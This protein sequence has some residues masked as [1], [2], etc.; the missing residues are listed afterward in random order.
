MSS[1]TFTRR[2]DAHSRCV[3]SSDADL[4][5]GRYVFINAPRNSGVVELGLSSSTSPVSH[6]TFMQFT[7]EQARAI[8]AELLACAD[9]H[10]AMPV[11][12][13]TVKGG[14]R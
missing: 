6:Q 8:A 9:V 14:A 5:G 12:D 13:S 10:E 4:S 7:P 3:F 1:I 11:A 2:M